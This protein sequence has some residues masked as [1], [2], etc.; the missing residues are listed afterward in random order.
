MQ[1]TTY[2]NVS[3]IAIIKRYNA[4]GLA[5]LSDQRHQNPGA[6]TL[7]SDS[8]ILLLAQNIRKDYALGKL[9][10]GRKVVSWVKEELGKEIHEQRAYEALA[11]INFS[12]QAPRPRHAKADLI[13]QESFKKRRF[14]KSS[15]QLMRVTKR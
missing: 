13:A 1:L 7:L 3:L 15:Q 9:W 12:L 5:G 10:N 14:P 11:A 8:E 4:E 6:P 2:A